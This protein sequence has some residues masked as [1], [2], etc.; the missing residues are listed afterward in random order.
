MHGIN[1]VNAIIGKRMGELAN[2][3][4]QLSKRITKALSSV[5]RNQHQPLIEWQLTQRSRFPIV[6]A[7]RNIVQR[8]HHCIARDVDI[9][10]A[11]SLP[12]QCL[13]SSFSR[14]KVSRCNEICQ[15]PINLF[16]ER[17]RSIAGSKARL[18]VAKCNSVVK[19]DH[20]GNKNS[21]GI[22]LSQNP[23]RFHLAH[24]GIQASEK[25]SGQLGEALIGLHQIE[26]IVRFDGKDTQY[27]VEHLAV[28]SH[29]ADHGTHAVR[30]SPELHNDRCHLDRLGPR[31]ENI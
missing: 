13:A 25:T 24:D 3:Q 27:L 23:V 1:K 7:R 15:S 18:N 29:R 11:T 14:R 22:A 31:A 2:C 12:K 8:I 21:R 19:S 16:R 6:F 9:P 10:V 26:V 28:L 17:P 30:L 20:R 4:T 5:R